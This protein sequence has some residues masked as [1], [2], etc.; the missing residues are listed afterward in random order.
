MKIEKLTDNKVRI[1]INIDEL[2]EKN[3]DFNSLST[4]TVKA[5]KLFKNILKQAEEEV[6][7]DSSNSKILI[8]A[9]F[10][11]EGFFI[12]TFT[13]INSDSKSISTKPLKLKIR[14]KSINK[15]LATAI[16][17]FDN[18][19]EFCNFCTYLNKTVLKDLKGFAK[20]LSLYEYK[21]NFYLVCNKVN[22]K[23]PNIG[24]FYNSIS[25]FAKLISSSLTFENVLL[26]FGKPVFKTN[27]IKNCIKYFADV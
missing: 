3:I 12:I 5:Q 25:E 26:E 20:T 19:E 1:I 18:F 2:H 4:D 10:S 11:S 15:I 27:A 21:S 16:Y 13:K 17:K 22:P 7:F 24:L 23:F 14:R 9:F 8:E 6:G